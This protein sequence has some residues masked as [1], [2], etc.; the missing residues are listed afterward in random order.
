MQSKLGSALETILNIGSGFV[1][2]MLIWQLIANPWFGYSVSLIE[3]IGLTSIFTVV[4]IT[5]SYLWRRFFNN[6][7]KEIS[8]VYSEGKYIKGVPCSK[9]EFLRGTSEAGPEGS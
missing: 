2:S 5:R 7:E 9:S 4:S 3:N 1:L 6:R 8:Y